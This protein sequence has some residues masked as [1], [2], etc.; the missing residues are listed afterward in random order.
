MLFLPAVAIY[1]GA[2]ST[3]V[4]TVVELGFWLWEIATSK[5]KSLKEGEDS[6][7]EV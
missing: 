5:S 6:E 7:S 2:E 3:S 4:L 1:M